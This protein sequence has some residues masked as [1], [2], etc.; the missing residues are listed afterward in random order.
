MLIEEDD[1]K[2]DHIKRTPDKKHYTGTS[3]SVIRTSQANLN[4]LLNKLDE[5]G[6]DIAKFCNYA[7]ETLMTLTNAGSTDKQT[8]LK[9]HEALV[10]SPGKD[11]NSEI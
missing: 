11:F 1:L 10:T 9:L 6:F 3:E 8:A 4:A 2:G 7:T 5:F